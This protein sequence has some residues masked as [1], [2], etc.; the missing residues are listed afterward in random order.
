MHDRLEITLIRLAT[1]LAAVSVLFGS[2]ER[3]TTVIEPIPVQSTKV[4][5]ALTSEDI[6][7]K[8]KEKAKM[9][10]FPNNS[11]AYARSV[12]KSDK[13]FTC[14][15]RLWGKESAWTHTADNPT[16]SAYG[17]PQALPGNK[18]ADMGKDWRTNPVTQIDWGLK[19]IRL[20][21]GDPCGAWSFFLKNNWY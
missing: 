5:L 9:K 12:V 17:I 2:V 18:M 1:V 4:V 20:R 3:D 16:S 15:N 21:Y 7:A 10:P 11:R 14:L 8:I 19:Y 13:Q 6:D